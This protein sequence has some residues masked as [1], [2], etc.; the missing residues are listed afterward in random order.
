MARR[1]P[2]RAIAYR[3]DPTAPNGRKRGVVG[4]TSA[5]DRGGLQAFIDRQEADG[6]VVDVIEVQPLDL[7]KVAEVDHHGRPRY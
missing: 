1:R 6:N 5:C 7:F 2:W 4:R 3:P